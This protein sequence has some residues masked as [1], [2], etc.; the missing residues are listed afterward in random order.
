[1]AVDLEVKEIV[2][3]VQ[4]LKAATMEKVAKVEGAVSDL[5]EKSAALSDRMLG[6]EQA[7]VKGLKNAGGGGDSAFEG[8]GQALM[9]K[10]DLIEQ[11]RDGTAKSIRFAVK[12]FHPIEQKAVTTATFP[13]VAARDPEMYYELT[14]P[15]SVRDLL[16][17]RPTAAGV[18]YVKAQRSGNAAPQYDPDTNTSDGALKKQLDVTFSL[19]NAKVS[20]IAC[21]VPVSRQALDDVEELQFFLNTTLLD[22]VREEEDRQ[23]LYGSGVANNLEGLMTQA[24]AYNRGQT[25]DRA[26]DTLR[27]A[28]T[29][30]QLARGTPTGIVLNPQGLERLELETD[31]QGRYLMTFDVTVNGRS[32]TWRVP[33]VATDAMAADDFLVGDF[34][35]AARLYDRQNATVMISLEHAD[36]FVRNMAAILA[37]ERLT[38][39]TPRPQLLVKGT[40]AAAA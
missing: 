29:Q 28:I 33:V 21:W 31:Q 8:P 17:T 23:L 18:E 38:L 2:A 34:V 20:T 25:G 14:R 10:R 35:R 39:A 30:V 24:T 4:H 6:M 26:N 3:A 12:G 22:A 7:L 1:M 32:V 11:L 16:I 15:M 9:E 37:E 36:F 40:F 19:E 13:V 27:R 5:N